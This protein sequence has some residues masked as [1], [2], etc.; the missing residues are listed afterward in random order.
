MA[1]WNTKFYIL[2]MYSLRDMNFLLGV[3]QSSSSAALTLHRRF[4]V[5]LFDQR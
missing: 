2:E 1:G 5:E 4:T 3:G